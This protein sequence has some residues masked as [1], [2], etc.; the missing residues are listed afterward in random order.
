MIE[1]KLTREID[2]AGATL[3]EG[4]PGIGLVGPMA[5]SYIIDKLEMKYIGY[6]ESEDFPPYNIDT[7][8]QAPPTCQALLFGQKKDRC[9]VR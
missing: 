2:F 6:F 8:Q 9:R 3:I 5:I 4:F 1:I 7:R